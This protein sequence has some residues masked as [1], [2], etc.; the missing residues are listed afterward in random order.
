MRRI[1][2]LLAAALLP[3]LGCVVP[4]AGTA[5]FVDMRGGDFWSG[6]GQ[7]LEVSDDE[8]RCL[9]SIRGRSL[10]VSERW[11]DCATVHPRNSRDHH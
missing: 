9:V 1:R 8:E 2:L 7:L 6:E 4:A 11:V 10:L 3:A 5:V